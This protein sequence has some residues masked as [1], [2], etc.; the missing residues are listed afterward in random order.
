MAMTEITLSFLAAL[1]AYLSWKRATLES[2]YEL[3]DTL[4]NR[5]SDSANVTNFYTYSL[6]RVQ[7][8]EHE[9]WGYALSKYLPYIG[10]TRGMTLVYLYFYSDEAR[11]SAALPSAEEIRNHSDFESMPISK[12][13]WGS[14]L[15]SRP[16][17]D[18][19]LEI[20]FEAVDPD[21]L[22]KT[23]TDLSGILI[24]LNREPDNEE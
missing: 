2:P 24:E 3:E 10:Q 19:N 4:R 9:G 7:V 16:E 18:K 1:F 12:I 20:V 8:S 21:V 13:A 17:G 14:E 23:I 6:G 5:L 15:S 11:S 22:L